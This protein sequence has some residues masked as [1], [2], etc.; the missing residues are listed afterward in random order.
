MNLVIILSYTLL[1]ATS[2]TITEPI[3]GETYEGD[4]LPFRVIVENENEIP[5]SV[6][7]SLNGE[8]LVSVQRLNTDWYTYMAN[9]CRTGFS[10]SP[11][12]HTNEILWTQ[13]VSGNEHEF[14]SPVIV[15]GRVY[16]SSEMNEI[17]YCLDAATGQEIWRF[18]NIGDAIDDAVHVENDRVYLASDSIWCLDAL[19]GERIWAFNDGEPYG[20]EGPPVPYDGMVFVSG[21]YVHALDAFSG[22]EIW[23]TAEEM[24]SRSSMTAWNGLLFV[25]EVMSLNACLY[26]LDTNDGDI[27]WAYETDYGFWDSSPCIV[28]SVIYIGSTGDDKMYAFDA[29]D[30]SVIWELVIGAIESTPACDGERVIFGSGDHIYSVDPIDGELEWQFLIPDCDILHGSPGIADGLVFWGD[31]TNEPTDSLALIHAV[32]ITTGLEVWNYLTTGGCIGIQSSPAIT[33]GVMYISATDSLLYAF[34]TGLKYTYK[35]DYFYADVGSNELIVISW[36]DGMAVAADTIS[37]TVTQ[38]GIALEPSSRL[39]LSANPNPLNNRT[40]ISFEL[41]EAGSV[42][43]QIFDLTGRLI[44]DLG[45]SNA[46]RGANTVTWDACNDNGVPVS[47]GLYFC[48]IKSDGVVETTGLCVL[49]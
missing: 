22:M 35:E 18:E 25:P 41:A 15:N 26:A 40:S 7:Y 23:K 13:P 11:A 16:Y 29:L 42:S 32:D 47:A 45:N 43:L 33:D 49:N 3:D 10:E 14:V 4:W 19:T 1:S 48:R 20:F 30:G 27:I 36:Y 21:Q 8:S 6:H 39:H 9:D 2:V 34:G 24:E 17:T 31:L 5:D 46:I 44:S 12:P 28:D 38:T 37:F